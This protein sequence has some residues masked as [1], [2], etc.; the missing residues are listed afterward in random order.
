MKKSLL[1]IFLSVVTCF[2]A[3]GQRLVTSQYTDRRGVTRYGYDINPRTGD[4]TLVVNMRPVYCF[5]R[6][7]DLRRY[8][9]M[10][11][12]LKIAYPIAQIAKAKM[13]NLEDTLDKIPTRRLQRAYIRSIEKA[14]KDEYTPVLG[15]MTRSQ[16]KILIRLIDRE[17]DYNTY[18]IVK[19]FRGGFVAGFW[20]GIA[21]IFGQDLKDEYDKENRDKVLEQ[22]IMLYE[23]DLL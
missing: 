12:D 5:K 23:A 6:P 3:F 20:Q 13:R 8:T 10:I 22:L 15:R 16:G 2:S 11:R 21:K 7:A 4:T 14:V 17:T 1:I 19:E 9:K 18:D